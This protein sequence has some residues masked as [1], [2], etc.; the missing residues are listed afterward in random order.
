MSSI[1][2]NSYFLLL[3]TLLLCHTQAQQS[4]VTRPN[5]QERCDP[6]VQCLLN[7]TTIPS[8]C[9]PLPLK[10]NAVIRYPR[11]GTFEL[12]M[13]RE[14][15]YV[16]RDFAGYLSL[17][18]KNE[19]RLTIVDAPDLPESPVFPLTNAILQVLNGTVPNQLDMIYTHAHY[20]HIGQARR[21]RDFLVNRFPN[22]SV[23]IWGTSETYDMIQNSISKRAVLPD[24]IIGR[25]GRTLV[26]SNSLS[27]KMEIVGGHT[28]EDVRIYIPPSNGEG[29]VVIFVDAV[30]PGYVPPV[31]FALTENLG[32][33][34][35]VQ[36]DILKLDF[37]FL[38]SGHLRVATREDVEENILYIEDVVKAAETTLRT[39]TIDRLLAAGS[40]QFDDP[41]SDVF[42]NY[43]FSFIGTRRRLEIEIC[44]R[45][46]VPKWG[47]RLAGL[48]FAAPGHCQ[49]AV[50]YVLLEL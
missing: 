6:V 18:I 17:I 26:L 21:V 45:I 30:F 14:G 4:N 16:F 25:G 29:G 41:T 5:F 20:D 1:Y 3:L 42:G 37:K 48:D 28:I 22:M 33:L 43:L 13:L 31:D 8:N 10:P 34:I 12:Q 7:S 38:V 23:T 44:F 46:L 50:N 11:F 36:R 9:P 49:T 15:V 39:L 2:R 35:Q 47:C 40:G 24:I 19:R 32:R 27:L